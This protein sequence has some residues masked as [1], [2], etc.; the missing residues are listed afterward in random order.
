MAQTDRGVDAVG[1]AGCVPVPAC[2]RVCVMC[3]CVLGAGACGQ[4]LEAWQHVQK[5]IVQLS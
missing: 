5:I 2:L 4:H 3:V 1:V